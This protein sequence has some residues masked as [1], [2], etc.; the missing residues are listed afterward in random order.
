MEGHCSPSTCVPAGLAPRPPCARP[1]SQ[2]NAP[3]CDDARVKGPS[4]RGISGAARVL[5]PTRRVANASHIAPCRAGNEEYDL[6]QGSRRFDCSALCCARF[7]DLRR[8]IVYIGG[9]PSPSVDPFRFDSGRSACV[10]ALCSA[11]ESLRKDTGVGSLAHS[12]EDQ[13]YIP[14]WPHLVREDRRT[15][16][17]P[18]SA[19]PADRF[20]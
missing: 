8:I 15:Y 17:S 14:Y 4:L 16:G 13:S 18:R 9:L 3:R 20:I 10:E 7:L 2:V 1:D 19:R 5:T 11:T 6:S 12:L